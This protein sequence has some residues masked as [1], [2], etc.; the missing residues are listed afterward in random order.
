MRSAPKPLHFLIGLSL[1][2]GGC[3]EGQI[4]SVQ[5]VVYGESDQL[6]VQPI[7]V[8]KDDGSNCAGVNLFADITAK[9]LE[10]A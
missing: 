4:Q 3:S 6:S 1:G 5:S 9:I 8:C 10:Q 2:L 7:Q